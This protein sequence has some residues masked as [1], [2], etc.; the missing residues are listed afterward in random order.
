MAKFGAS[1]ANINAW[2]AYKFLDTL[3]I[4]ANLTVFYHIL[5]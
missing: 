2:V 3:E 5:A 4:G 1:I